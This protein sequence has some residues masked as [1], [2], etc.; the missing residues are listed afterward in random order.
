MHTLENLV[1]NEVE[2]SETSDSLTVTQGNCSATREVQESAMKI[3]L[4]DAMEIVNSLKKTPEIETC[5]DFG[6]AFIRKLISMSSGYDEVHLIF[7]RYLE[8]SLKTQTRQGRNKNLKSTYYHVSDSTLIKNISLKEFLADTR[9]KAELCEYLS[10]KA[11]IIS[12]GPDYKLKRF[13][14]TYNTITEGNVFVNPNLRNHNHEEADTLLILHASSLD[15]SSYVVV[16][17]PDTDVLL[18][19]IS[20]YDHLSNNI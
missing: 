6:N 5:A 2:I 16:H 4:F 1:D 12:R 19:L 13:F 14:V 3:I 7:D 20:L 10:K 8:N 17:S 18:L 9:T 15:L 11:L